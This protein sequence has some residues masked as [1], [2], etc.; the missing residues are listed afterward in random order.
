VNMTTWKFGPTRTHHEV[1]R[2]QTTPY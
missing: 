2:F 1:R